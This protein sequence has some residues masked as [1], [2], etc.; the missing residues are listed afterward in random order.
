MVTGEELRAAR[1]LRQGEE[2]VRRLE[3]ATVGVAG[4][5]GLGSHI[6]VLLARLGV[7]RLVLADFDKV[8]V[9]NLHRQHYFL[10]QLGMRKTDAL[11]AQLRE[12]DPGLL[13]ETHA[14]RVTAENAVP[15]F[16]DCDVVCEA[17]DRPDQ[18]AMLIETLLAGLPAVRVVAGSGMAGIA[19]TN[20][21]RTERA[22]RRL[23]I[24]GDRETDVEAAG[25]LTASRVVT[26][27][28]HE[29]HMALRLLLGQEAP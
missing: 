19:S 11:A 26:C 15:L 4:L 13:Y 10:P 16:R 21:I 9:T 6:A 3:A 24:C 23:Y 25:S 12:I 18:K 1:V 20:D 5:G 27:A 2:T 7:G 22:F 8:D 28:A 29:A 14:L 17:F